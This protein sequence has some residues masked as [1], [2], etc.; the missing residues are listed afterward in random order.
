MERTLDIRVRS[1]IMISIEVYENSLFKQ[2][3]V[4]NTICNIIIWVIY[5][6]KQLLSYYSIA[7]ILNTESRS[8]LVFVY[9]IK[10]IMLDIIT[11]SET[12]S[13]S[14]KCKE[15]RI[16]DNLMIYFTCWHVTNT[17]VQTNSPAITWAAVVC[18]NIGFDCVIARC[19]ITSIVSVVGSSVPIDIKQAFYKTRGSMEL[20]F[21]QNYL[22][23][24]ICL[25]LKIIHTV[26]TFLRKVEEIKFG[27][28]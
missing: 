19:V 26:R 4:W 16:P 6:F 24:R 5:K 20:I 22:N 27:F 12:I 13:L 3:N 14:M 28:E 11:R 1:V 9:S 8:S 17:A 23:I 18:K 21:I 15:I 7:S 2:H 25:Y 10:S